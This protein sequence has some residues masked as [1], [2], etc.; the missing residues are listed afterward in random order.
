[1]ASS[2]RDNPT[3]PPTRRPV[4]H[5]AEHHHAAG[6]E[7]ETSH[8]ER[9]T[10]Q[11]HH[12]SGEPAVNVFGDENNGEHGRSDTQRPTVGVVRLTRSM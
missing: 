9:G 10:N 7:T 11:T 6:V 5:L 2:D 4:L 8:E 3:K 1:M 12:G